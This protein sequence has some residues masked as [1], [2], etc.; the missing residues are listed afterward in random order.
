[1]SAASDERPEHLNPR[2]VKEL[3]DGTPSGLYQL[4]T[5]LSGPLG[6]VDSHERRYIPPSLAL[7]LWHCSDTGCLSKHSVE[8]D[9]PADIALVEVFSK[10]EHA[11][12]RRLGTPSE[13]GTPLRRLLLGSL[14]ALEREY[15]DLL[16]VLSECL[17][18]QETHSLLEAALSS[19]LAGQLRRTLASTAENSAL[20]RRSDAEILS[21][22]GPT[23]QVQFLASLSNSEI[24]ELLENVIRV[25]LVFIPKTEIRRVTSVPPRMG[26]RNALSEISNLSIRRQARQPVRIPTLS[27]VGLTYDAYENLNRMGDLE[28]KLRD[29]PGAS[30]KSKLMEYLRR[31]GPDSVVSN[32][33]L[34]HVPIANQVAEELKIRFGEEERDDALVE[35]I[36]WRMGFDLPCDRDTDKTLRRRLDYFEQTAQGCT[37]QDRES[38]QEAIRSAGANLF[39]SVERF[40]EDLLAFSV[41]L[42][43]SDHFVDTK[44]TYRP[45]EA[46]RLVARVLGEKVSAADGD[47]FWGERNTLGVL[48]AYLQVCASWIKGLPTSDITALLRPEADLPHFSDWP[49][50]LFAFRHTQLWADAKPEE[51]TRYIRGFEEITLQILQSN[52]AGIRN[53]LDHDRRDADFPS[54]E[55]ILKFVDHFRRAA[56]TADRL[57]YSPKWWWLWRT[58]TDRYGMFEYQLRDY[59]QQELILRGPSQV[60]GI[61]ELE[62]S[63]PVIVASGNLLGEPNAE[64][65]LKA[66][67]SSSYLD[68]WKGYPRRRRLPHVPARAAEPVPTPEGDHSDSSS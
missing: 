5:L 41:W 62:L 46:S 9:P 4:G 35:R 28:W 3:L 52:L 44:F 30:T 58:T 56:N 20:S 43:A 1:L 6:F 25:G 68:Y 66:K 48:I 33:I 40:L 21:V 60:V 18:P 38:D 16:V 17:T 64:I 50:R 34:S 47:K 31:N 49:N 12:R 45:Q 22:L 19:D 13:W 63:S 27:L 32:L 39:V 29:V 23:A 2:E 65:V 67:E 61:P 42:L 24:V 53:G 59:A 8:L 14:E 57:R 36:L 26:K 55:A 11:A 10:L 7:P 15:H 51:L 37:W 54:V